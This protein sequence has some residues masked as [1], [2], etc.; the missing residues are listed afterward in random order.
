MRLS[1]SAP[2]SSPRDAPKGPF[3]EAPL[4][5]ALDPALDPALEH[6][7]EHTPPPGTPSG[8]PYPAAP[9]AR[10]ALPGGVRR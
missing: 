7:L 3:S 5:P 2:P 9:R 4:G 6:T 8:H 10:W 1:L